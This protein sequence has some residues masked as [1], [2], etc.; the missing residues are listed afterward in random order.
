ML[1]ALDAIEVLWPVFVAIGSFIIY[2]LVPYLQTKI[3]KNKYVNEEVTFF[4]I[5]YEMM[6][7]IVMQVLI[8]LGIILGGESSW[9]KL[10]ASEYIIAWIV[11]TVLYL[12][13]IGIIVLIRKK[14]GKKRYIKNILLGG[15][16]HL[17]LS[18]QLILMLA[19]AYEDKMDWFFYLTVFCVLLIQISENLEPKRVKNVRC[20]VYVGENT[21]YDTPYEPIKR[22]K[23]YYVRIVDG[24]KKEIKR[25]QIPEDKIK[26][27]EY[28]IEDLEENEK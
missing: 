28:I 7:S 14:E 17:I 22:G 8:V 11:V 12:I 20:L 5:G 24:N 23:Y 9:E 18:G 15:F 10:V 27:I 25:I 4:L 2:K 19:D 21:T 6:G 13:G 1:D 16:V 3:F 26:R